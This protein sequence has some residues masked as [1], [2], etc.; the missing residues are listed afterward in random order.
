MATEEALLSYK[1]AN[2]EVPST[3]TNQ[4][5][6]KEAFSSNLKNLNPQFVIEWLLDIVS[7]GYGF[8]KL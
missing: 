4:I 3:T 5:D 2:Y 8:T 6:S 7:I 1:D